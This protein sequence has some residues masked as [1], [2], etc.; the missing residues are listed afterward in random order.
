MLRQ[1]FTV[2]AV[3]VL[4]AGCSDGNKPVSKT[5]D[6][7]PSAT[8]PTAPTLTAYDPPKAFTATAALPQ[9]TVPK[10]PTFKPKAGM[11]GQTVVVADL[12]GLYGQNVAN[13][14]APWQLP[15]TEVTTVETLD[16]TAPMS[17]QLNGK[18]AIAVAYYQRVQGSGTNKAKVQVVFQWADPTDG[19]AMAAATINVTPT[20]GEDELTAGLSAG[21]TSETVDAATGQVAVGLSP[22]SLMGAKSGI[23]TVFG[24]PATKK[25]ATLPFVEPAGVANG[26]VVGAKGRE[27]N[28]RSL[29]V[30]DATTGA[31]K[32]TG[33]TGLDALHPAGFGPKH[34][35]LSAEK[36]IPATK[37]EI[38]GHY[39]NSIYAIDPATG[40]AVQ[41]LS[42]VKDAQEALF[43][44]WGDSKNS[45]VCTSHA[46]GQAEIIG[47]DDTTGKKTWGYTE[48][49]GSRVVPKITAAFH[50]LVY[51]QA[52]AGPALLDATTGHDV[53]SPTPTPAGNATPTDGST[54]TAGSTPSDGS[55]PT[56]GLTP[57]DNDSPGAVLDAKPASPDAVS[58]YGGAYLKEPDAGDSTVSAVLM[59]L[60]AVG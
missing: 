46:R 55:T 21:F 37:N 15:S 54:P 14:G 2:A 49:S 18:D 48:K 43:T 44:C 45:V 50:G 47:I 32:K 30:V 6:G 58:A 59:I 52:E 60:K 3:V 7:Q 51:A 22:L 35:Y 16:A 41:T 5:G 31:V 13:Q 12:R 34:A 1:V 27:L 20:I 17:V 25:T 19:K 4:I 10:H 28:S 33:L 9:G 26:I 40:A 56:I 29:A 11:V 57:T 53:P 23:F 38:L 8:T 42:V 24:D 36:Y 39:V